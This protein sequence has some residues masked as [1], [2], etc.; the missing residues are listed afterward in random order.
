MRAIHIV[1]GV[2]RPDRELLERQLAS[3]AAQTHRPLSL[4]ACL[5]GPEALDAAGRAALAAALEGRHV[6]LEVHTAEANRGVARN[7]L[8]GLGRAVAAAGPDALFAFADQDDRWA[9]DKLA[10]QA[11]VL[12]E[13]GVALCHHDARLVDR[14]GIETAP[15]MFALERRIAEPD[16]VDLFFVNGVTGMTAAMTRETAARVARGMPAGTP[17]L[18]DHW[19]ALVAMACG[20]LRRI[21]APLADYVQHG[22]NQIGAGRKPPIAWSRGLSETRGT[23][24]RLRSG[25]EG[26]RAVFAALAAAAGDAPGWPAMAARLAPLLAERPDPRALLAEIRRARRLPTPDVRANLLRHAAGAAAARLGLGAEDPA[27]PAS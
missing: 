1:M 27:L 24:A 14:R 11:E 10:R 17:I 3:I 6:A 13:P 26:R 23:L 5:D 18:H 2:W 7:V 16:P 8:A 19:A 21:E 4:H 12:G 15:S 20:R 9:P 25:F 22:A